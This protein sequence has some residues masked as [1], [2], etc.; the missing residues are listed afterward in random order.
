MVVFDWFS[1]GCI[2]AFWPYRKL[3]AAIGLIVE[4]VL[5]EQGVAPFLQASGA[6]VLSPPDNAGL[7]TSPFP[8]LIDL[9]QALP[10]GGGEGGGEH[11]I[12][13]FLC[14]SGSV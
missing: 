4:I 1:E 12:S 11:L 6:P 7:G 2:F 8:R 14:V 5:L 9:L 13:V 3:A 10:T